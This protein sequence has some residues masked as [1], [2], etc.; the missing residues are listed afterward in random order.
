MIW[1]GLGLV[2]GFSYLSSFFFV[3]EPA[4]AS[5]LVQEQPIK[6]VSVCRV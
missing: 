2:G 1:C 5:P 4:G 6:I 3:L